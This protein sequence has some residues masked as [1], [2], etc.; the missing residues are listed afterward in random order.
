MSKTL[1]RGLELIEEVGRNGPMTV[2]ELAR[3]TGVHITIVSRTI[4]ACEPEGWLVRVDGKVLPG[5]RCALLG[6]TSPVSST[7]REAEPLVRA[8]AAIT[9]LAASADGLVGDDLML[10]TSFGTAG[11]T[12]LAGALSRVPVYVMAAGRAVAA[13]LSADQ[14]DVV[15]P[16]EPFPDAEQLL[17]ALHQVG[18]TSS[19]LSGFQ[20]D[21]DPAAALPRTRA[22]LDTELEA[23]R[24]GGFARDHGAIHPSIHCIAAPWPTGTLPAAFACFGSRETIEG[25]TGL[26]ESTLRAV[27]KPGATAQDV[28]DAA[29]AR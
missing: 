18:P 22:E 15:L 14:L 29:A 21:R 25:Q 16:A 19:Y 24:A 11:A 3:R 9:G 13:Q 27:T 28:I 6:M 12:D 7:I 1:L 26:I 5:P 2:T 20:A 23:I 17:A 10:L 4:K 8:I